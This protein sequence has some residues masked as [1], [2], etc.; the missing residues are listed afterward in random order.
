[1]RG[2]F[3]EDCEQWCERRLLARINRY[4]VKRLRQEI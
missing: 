2:S 1:M 3:T 4:T